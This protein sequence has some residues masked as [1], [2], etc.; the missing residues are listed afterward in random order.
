RIDFVDEHLDRLPDAG[1][2]QFGADRLL[3]LHQ[4]VVARLLHLLGNGAGK[5]VGGGAVHVL[6]FETADARKLGRGKP[7]EKAGEILL[8]LSREADDKGRA[9]G[10]LGTNLTPAF[11]A[12]QGPLLVA[13]TPHRL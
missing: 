2:E 13:G 5:L 10:E 1:G 3:M 8:G 4:T 6:I 7:S 12:L 9:D 11:D